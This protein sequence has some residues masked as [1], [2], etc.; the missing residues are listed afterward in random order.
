MPSRDHQE[1]ASPA[2]AHQRESTPRARPLGSGSSNSRFAAKS[3]RAGEVDG[4][5][6]F[7]SLAATFAVHVADGRIEE[8]VASDLL[9]DVLLDLVLIFEASKR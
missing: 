5:A 7:D 1:A 6:V 3:G 8:A 4:T 2:V 9:G